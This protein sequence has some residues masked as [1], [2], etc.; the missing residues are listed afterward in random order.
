MCQTQAGL[1]KG[2]K[3]ELAAVDT[4]SVL[5]FVCVNHDAWQDRFYFSNL[6]NQ[7]GDG[8]P[9]IQDEQDNDDLNVWSRY[10]ADKDDI[11]VID[12][13]GR[14]AHFFAKPD[15]FLDKSNVKDA[16][17]DVLSGSPCDQRK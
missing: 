3:E 14:V 4:E 5:D 13:Q 17:L 8:I 7:A 2:L 16:V 15:S 12:K 1:L 6:K 10:D 9:I 11:Y